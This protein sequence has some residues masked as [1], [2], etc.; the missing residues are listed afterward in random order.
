MELVE[1]RELYRN[2]DQYI[3]KRISVGG[4]IAA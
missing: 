2:K 1:V 3:G 4:W